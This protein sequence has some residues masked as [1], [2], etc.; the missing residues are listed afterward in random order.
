MVFHLD[1]LSVN[2]FYLSLQLRRALV[3]EAALRLCAFS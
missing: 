1:Q 3:P 2:T